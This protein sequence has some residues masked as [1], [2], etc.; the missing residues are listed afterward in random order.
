M[1]PLFLASCS[2]PDI[3]HLKLFWFFLLINSFSLTCLRKLSE[4]ILRIIQ[5]HKYVRYLGKIRIPQI[6]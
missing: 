2:I 4:L 5:T 6:K 1:Q 3:G